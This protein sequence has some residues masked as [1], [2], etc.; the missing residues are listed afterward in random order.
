MG[1]LSKIVPFFSDFSPISSQFHAFFAH[2]P[3]G[4]AIS[5]TSPF[6]PISPQFPPL[7]PTFPHSPPFSPIFNFPHVPKPR[8]PGGYFG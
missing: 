8:W 4:L 1:K 5:Q 6:P 3:N 2:F 7:F